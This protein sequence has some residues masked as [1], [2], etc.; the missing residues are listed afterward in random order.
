MENLN[1]ER[2]IISLQTMK[3]NLAQ[4]V[5]EVANANSHKIII[6]NNKA[7]AILLSVSDYQAMQDRL[8]AME[9]EI[10]LREMRE[11]DARGELV[12]WDDLVAELGIELSEIPDEPEGYD[13]RVPKRY[14]S[15]S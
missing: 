4:I 3:K 11:E 5:D 14:Q 7:T 13:L 6:K 1:P 12:D 8:Q 2:D 9:L 15:A 10:S